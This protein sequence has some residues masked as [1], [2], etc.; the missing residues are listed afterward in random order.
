MNAQT[1][2][3]EI[4]KNAIV[5][6]NPDPSGEP[7]LA[8]GI[9]REEWASSIANIP[10]LGPPPRNILGKIRAKPLPDKVD[11]S[12]T[13]HFRPVFEQKGGSCAQAS[14][15]GYAFTYEL[16]YLRGLPGNVAD[17]QYP[18]DFTYNLVN[19]G[20]GN[21]GSYPTQAWAIAKSLGIP[22]VTSYGGFGLG[23]FKQWVS[24]YSIYYNAMTNRIS[25]DFT[26]NTSKPEGVTKMKQW[27]YDHQNGS[28]QGG[29]LVMCY[30]ATGE[31]LATIKP[32]L[33]EAGKKI[34]YQFGYDGGH[35]ITIVGYND[36]V[37]YD[38]NKDG[39]FT[40]SSATDVKTWEI[41]AYLIVN[42]W[43]TS[44]GNSGKALIPYRLLA[45]P[46][47]G[48]WESKLYGMKTLEEKV[49]KP[50]LTYKIVM[51]HS[52]RNQIRMKAGYANS[53]TASA[54]TDT[55]MNFA[56][57]FSSSMSGALPM[58]GITSDP[59]EIGLDVSSFAPKLTNSEVSFFLVIESRG[60]TGNV[61]SF[62][63]LDYTGSET[64]VEIPCSRTN[65][66]LPT[67]TTTLKITRTMQPIMALTPN[68]S[69]QLE[70]GRTF[71]ITWY[72]RLSEN[73][74]IELLK[75]N[76]AALTIAASAPSDGSYEWTVPPDLTVGKD[77]KIKISSV[78]DATL[79]DMSDSNFS[80]Q[81]KTLLDITSPV[82]GEYFEKG[83]AVPITWNSSATGG[84]IIDLYKDRMPETTLISNFTG[85]GPYSWTPSMKFPSGYTYS[86]RLT[87]KANPLAFD[88]SKVYFSIVQP[89]IKGP[90]TQNF[91]KFNA[92]DSVVLIDN[93][94]QSRDD[95]LD[96]FVHKGPTPSKVTTAAGGKGTGP[97]ADHTTGKNNFI[98]LESSYPNNPT[99]LA[100]LLSPMINTHGLGNIK[101]GFW[102]HMYSRDGHMGDLFAD[103]F[104]DGVW[105][106]SVV[107]FTGDHGDTWHE[108]SIAL[109]DIS[110]QL[111]RF[112][113][114]VQVRFR[115]TTGTDYDGDIC[116]DDFSVTGDPV[117]ANPLQPIASVRP[118]IR[119][120]GNKIK[121]NHMQ[122][123]LS[124][125]RLNGSKVANF[126]VK[127]SG[128][129]DCSKLSHGV[130]CIK[131][132]HQ[133][134]RIIR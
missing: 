116:L 84:L 63:V 52:Q 104:T 134:I 40:N 2:S 6:V 67:G 100:V 79:S 130:Y 123:C 96:W 58:Q 77:Y 24:G 120:F 17:N 64:P 80:V 118:E 54:A 90:I 55:L 125:I 124:I 94:E 49:F 70:R 110:T 26:I 5:N 121:Y 23:K 126:T 131:S 1:S 8:G 30:N 42:S 59:I 3:P 43:G 127:G 103:I 76:S 65:V 36:S 66:D 7:W 39:K 9:T 56:K 41:G 34:M 21:N 32:G 133:T 107:H 10:E 35:A 128:T 13:T 16:N 29:C 73:V 45:D 81:E 46:N 111:P 38:F 87:S 72:D 4:K 117:S 83:K 114:R 57:A 99:K 113:S 50:L 69:E 78:N 27:L 18:Y 97:N 92:A 14:S 112:V 51:S 109:A 129:I 82:G 102:Y 44:F 101:I 31:A 122:G 93:W 105:N 68:G 86:I 15:I 91:D 85:S 108:K 98:Y 25:G 88:E 37:C 22:N 61:S 48:V 132:N 89:I 119:I 53:A 20:S 12:A 106:D 33:P 115:G 19:A 74:K 95:E 28:S 47:N 75:N 62:S 60:G 71:T 11:N